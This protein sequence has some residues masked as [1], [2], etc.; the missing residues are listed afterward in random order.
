MSRACFSA[1]VI[2]IWCRDID[3]EWRF[4]L[5]NI[6]SG[7]R[8]PAGTLRYSGSDRKREEMSLSSSL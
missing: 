4:M 8:I 2:A 3:S 5:M 6:A 7:L 1:V